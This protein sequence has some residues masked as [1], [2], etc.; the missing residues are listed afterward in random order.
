MT[1]LH[2]F[3]AAGRMEWIKLS[4]LRSTW[5]TLAATV[6]GAT[7]I[8]IAVGASSRDA[9]A[10]VTNNVLAGVA[11]GLLLV[12]VL[13]V[14]TMTSEYSSGMIRATLA[15]VPARPVLLAAKAAVF[16]AVTLVL[17]EVTAFVAFLTGRA[18][19]H[20]GPPAPGLG[21][22]GVLRAVV[23]TGVGVALMGLFGLGLGAVVRHS[24][25]ALAT[26]VGVVFVVGQLLLAVAPSAVRYVPLAL[27]G[28]SLGVSRTAAGDLS[29]WTGLAVLSA[30]AAVALAAGAWT[31]TRRDA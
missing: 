31:L 17:G 13:G 4:T 25:A 7:G 29:P 18:A 5:W 3:T 15:A 11:P 10:D 24:A 14:L 1:T 12:G 9:S 23:L 20:G 30:Y 6:A 28:D 27:V 8:G 2:R 26:Y 16:G 22:P 21:D 19:L